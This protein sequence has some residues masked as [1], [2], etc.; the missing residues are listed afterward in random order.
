[1]FRPS[2]TGLAVGARRAGIVL[3]RWG[4]CRI[5]GAQFGLRD[6]HDMQLPAVGIGTRCARSPSPSGVRPIADTAARFTSVP[7]RPTGQAGKDGP[8]CGH[9]LPMF[10]PYL[11]TIEQAFNTC[12][13]F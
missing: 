11:G 10:Q 4:R 1:M 7:R 5:R 6:Q 2:L 8:G 9:T 12:S 13:N 3:D